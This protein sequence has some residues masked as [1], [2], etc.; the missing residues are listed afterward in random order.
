[1]RKRETG[2]KITLGWLREFPFRLLTGA[3]GRI[4]A[5]V[6]VVLCR[7]KSEWN[8]PQVYRRF[9][10]VVR[11]VWGRLP[12]CAASRFEIG[13]STDRD[14]LST[15]ARSGGASVGVGPSFAPL[16]LGI[17]Q[18]LIQECRPGVSL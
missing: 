2:W 14:L 11:H 17:R 7:T 10:W 4:R 12:A 3:E 6:G 13:Q 1:M 16:W 15:C 18:V 9:R 8:N 5:E